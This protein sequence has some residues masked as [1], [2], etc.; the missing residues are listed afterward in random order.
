M[1]D[2]VK[3]TDVQVAEFL[4]EFRDRELDGQEASPVYQELIQFPQWQ[5]ARYVED[6]APGTAPNVP[7]AELPDPREPSRTRLATEERPEPT[8]QPQAVVSQNAESRS[9]TTDAK[10]NMANPWANTGSPPQTGTVFLANE[11]NTPPPWPGEWVR[12]DGGWLRPS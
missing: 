1:G 10:S 4:A 3:V 7:S 5:T 9:I 8:P 11:T 2:E 6:E 12:R